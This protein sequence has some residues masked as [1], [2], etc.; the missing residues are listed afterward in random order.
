MLEN[1]VEKKL[2]NIGL[3]NEY[4]NKSEIGLFLRICF[5]LPFSSPEILSNV[6]VSK[7]ITIVPEK[8][9]EFTDYILDNYI[10]ENTQ[11]PPSMRT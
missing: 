10:S 1:K 3:A 4:K 8:C 7:I 6:F 9:L 2:Q 11:F 5:G